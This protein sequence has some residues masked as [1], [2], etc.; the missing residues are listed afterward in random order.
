[1]IF[2]VNWYL[3]IKTALA[4]VGLARVEDLQEAVDR[5]SSSI[6]R[7][8]A[9]L[10]GQE[11]GPIESEVSIIWQCAC[12]MSGTEDTGLFLSSWCFLFCGKWPADCFKCNVE[13]NCA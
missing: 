3:S 10:L 7:A 9:K 6:Q 1:M 12:W 8:K 4:E 11:P 2:S 5:L 13:A